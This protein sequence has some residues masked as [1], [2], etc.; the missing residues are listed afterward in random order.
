MEQLQAEESEADAKPGQRRDLSQSGA[1]ARANRR[2]TVDKSV[3]QSGAEKETRTDLGLAM[4]R[5]VYAV[6][7]VHYSLQ[8]IAIWAGCTDANI[9]RIEV[10][11]LRR[12][13]RAFSGIGDRDIGELLRDMRGEG[14]AR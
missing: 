3:G 8:E 13:R 12:L 14:V 6:P 4:L 7:G 2:A 11:G 5:E 10:K 1:A 9:R